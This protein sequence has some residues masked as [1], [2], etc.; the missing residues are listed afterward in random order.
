[1]CPADERHHYIVTDYINPSNADPLYL[2]PNFVIT[3]HADI[4]G[5]KKCYDIGRPTNQKPFLNSCLLQIW[6]EPVLKIPV[7]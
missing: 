1:M 6:P 4:I 5:P 3:V 2:R 7:N